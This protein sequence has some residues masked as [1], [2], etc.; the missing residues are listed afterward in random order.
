MYEACVCVCVCVCMC[1]EAVQRVTLQL[2]IFSHLYMGFGGQTQAARFV[3]QAS[4]HPIP[5][6]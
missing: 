5:A 2:I 1:G 4:C 3:Q 6:T